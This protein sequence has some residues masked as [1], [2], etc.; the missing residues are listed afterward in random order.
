MNFCKNILKLGRGVI[1]KSQSLK[2]TP[3]AIK[4]DRVH[5]VGDV[6]KLEEDQYFGV[7]KI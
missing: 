6:D 4:H 3:L 1:I 7:S 5:R 2:L